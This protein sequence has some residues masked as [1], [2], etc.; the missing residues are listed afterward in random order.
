MNTSTYIYPTKFIKEI[1]TSLRTFRKSEIFNRRIKDDGLL[2]EIK[3]RIV[4]LDNCQER[5]IGR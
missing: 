1:D 2:F 3:N 5:E 4:Y